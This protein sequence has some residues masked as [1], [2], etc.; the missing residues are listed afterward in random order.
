MIAGRTLVAF[1]VKESLFTGS[2]Y[3]RDK[4]MR[5]FGNFQVFSVHLRL[6]IIQTPPQHQQ[7][8]QQLHS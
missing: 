2:V 1:G 6:S 3:P 8:Q 5:S 7:Q 4:R